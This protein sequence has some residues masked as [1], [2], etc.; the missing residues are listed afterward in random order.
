M[1]MLPTLRPWTLVLVCALAVPALAQPYRFGCHY[2]RNEAH[3]PHQPT[4][5]SDRGGI[6]NT[7]A[8]SDTF[9]LLHYDI[10]IDITDY[11]GHTIKAATTI[12]Y[13]AL[14]GGADLT[15]DLIDALVVDSV[16]S[17]AGPLPFTHTNNLVTVDLPPMN[18][19]DTG[20][21]TVHYHGTPGDDPEWGGFY[22][23]ST[24]I[25]NL[26]IGLSTIPPNFGK[27]WYPCFDSFVERASYT[28]HVK[29]SGTFRAHCQGD[30]LG[31]TQLGGDT[32]IRSYDLQQQ[33]TTHI[34]AIA[35]CNYVDSNYVHSGA[36]GDI[37]V[38]LTAKAGDINDM[39]AK[40]VSLGDAIDTYEFWYGPYPYDRV[41]YVLTTDGA[42]EIPENVAYP[43]FM[44][45][46]PL[47]DNRGLFGHEL[48]HHWW[49]DHITPR[50]HN[51]MWFKEGPAEYSAHLLEEWA[52]GHDAFVDVVKD[53]MLYVLEQA[54]LQDGGFQALSPMPDEYIYGLHTYYKGAA[55]MHNL[56][57][58]LG[59]TLF[60]QAMRTV[61]VEHANENMDASGFLGALESATGVQLDDFFNAQ[62]YSPGFS[63]FTVQSVSSAPDQGNF[64]VDL[65]LRQRLRGT[66]TMHLSVP[67]DVTLINANGQ[68]QE[69]Q[70]TASGATTELQLTCAFEPAMVVLNGHN[71]LNQARMDHEFTVVPGESFP[72]SVPRCAF[73][74]YQDELVD[75][76]LIR[77]EHIWAGANED[78]MDWG[79]F[80]VSNTHYWTVDGL[81]PEGTRLNARV[82][83]EA[84]E[85][86]L[87]FDL[88]GDTE[89]DAVLV[90]RSNAEAPWSLCPDVTLSLGNLTDGNGYM[91]IDTLRKGQYAFANGNVVIGVPQQWTDDASLIVLPNPANDR[92]T[93]RCSI[94]GQATLLFD[95][96][97]TDGKLVQRSTGSMS[98]TSTKRIDVQD[99]TAGTYVLKVHDAGGEAIGSARFTIDRP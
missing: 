36:Y 88:Y 15:L 19:G 14:I 30:F 91:L 61:Q 62:V 35:A 65:V 7:I 5:F 13:V 56:R 57:G 63:V 75:S 58:Y 80:E 68:R 77:V 99:M 66:S 11:S 18:T 20:E 31:E 64:L 95:V 98:G 52:F 72:S 16:T 54:H 12:T 85:T 40:M 71:R 87:D 81:W 32:V 59:D 3:H 28:Y 9:D 17:T 97:S 49:G 4:D 39:A 48:G 10:A 33:I 6:H 42:L 70:V 96:F 53:N 50:T 27:V 1:T 73:R 37:P 43:N 38:R 86:E 78:P 83:Y 90:Y 79:I 23:E 76:T 2:F 67:L 84:D 82:T 55:V 24:Y 93:V 8:R 21:V 94:E 22:F 44:P 69:Y 46:Q 92:I 47:F 26:G 74:I 29:S 60:R 51:D 25:Y 34:S 89:A 41:G 45:D